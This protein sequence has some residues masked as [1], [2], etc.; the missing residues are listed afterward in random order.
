MKDTKISIA[1]TRLC[2]FSRCYAVGATNYEDV[3]GISSTNDP[4]S[5]LEQLSIAHL[6]LSKIEKLCSVHHL[7]MLKFRYGFS[8]H[9]GDDVSLGILAELV[10]STNSDIGRYIVINWRSGTRAG[11]TLAAT[12]GI[13]ERTSRRLVSKSK[14]KLDNQLLK[15]HSDLDLQIKALLIEYGLYNNL[16][17]P[18]S[19]D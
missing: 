7:A 10:Y 8:D 17:K 12:Y 1:L 16:A 15:F 13:H 4:K 6:V 11:V 18:F 19:L 14:E 2:N 5:L 9:F 3:L